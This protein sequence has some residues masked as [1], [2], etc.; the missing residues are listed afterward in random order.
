M[1]IIQNIQK[2]LWLKKNK[3]LPA[4]IHIPKTGG[5]YI[6]QLETTKKPVIWPMKYFGHCCV[7]DTDKLI[8]ENYPPQRGYKDKPIIDINLLKDNYFTFA[9]VRNI[10]DWL[11][12]YWG[13]AGG[14]NNKYKNTN[15]Y[16]YQIAQKGFDYLIKT[17]V[18]RTDK[19]PSRKFI[20]FAIFSYHGDLAVDWLNR[21]ET[22]DKDLSELAKYKNLSY[23]KK[24]KQRLG[25]RKKDHREYYTPELIK[26][27]NDTW[28]RELDLFGYS[29][30]GLNIQ[31]AIIK[32]QVTENQKNNIKYYWE[33]DNLIID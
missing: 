28:Q 32:N 26:L 19:W 3:K 31:N 29:F 15:H 8:A 7:A 27:V 5:T 14:H 25:T 33:Q 30:D 20:H 11:V 16:D 21:I 9:T 17:I 10:F 12:S 13:H 23:K 24:E 1:T 4:F 6:S 22:L 2:K 18:N